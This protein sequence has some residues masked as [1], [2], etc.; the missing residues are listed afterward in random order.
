MLSQKQ[1]NRIKLKMHDV[2]QNDFWVNIFYNKN[3][4]NKTTLITWKTWHE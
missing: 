3:V 4:E 1:R 2:T